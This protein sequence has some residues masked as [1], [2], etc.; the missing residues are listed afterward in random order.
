MRINGQWVGWGLGDNS[1]GDFT[2]RNFK[3]FARRMYRSYMG[4]LDDT[5]VFDQQLQDALVI[6][7]DRLVAGRQLAPGR[8]IRGVL[9][10]PTQIASG[11][12]KPNR[13]IIF[14]VEGH[15]STPWV[16]PCAFIAQ[17]LEAEGL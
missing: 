8:F 3:E 6:M 14:T 5:N 4:H 9:D 15:L 17:Q 7:Q 1:S 10:L 13:P 11:F 16:G 2:V 12:K